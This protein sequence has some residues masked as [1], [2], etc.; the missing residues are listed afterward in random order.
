[1]SPCICSHINLCIR[2]EVV[3]HN[4][5]QVC[6]SLGRKFNGWAIRWVLFNWVFAKSN[7]N[8]SL[9]GWLTP[10]D[11]FCQLMTATACC[12]GSSATWLVAASAAAAATVAAA[13]AASHATNWMKL[14]NTSTYRSSFFVWG[15]WMTWQILEVHKILQE[16]NYLSLARIF[17][18]LFTK[19]HGD[20]M[21]N[22][23]QIKGLKFKQKHEYA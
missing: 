1:M 22:G 21:H 12:R 20:F 2:P 6:C 10:V 13:T 4:F 17:W 18:R 7:F 14:P 3:L 11:G 23:L 16:N 19:R 15:N 9:L 8:I 5:P